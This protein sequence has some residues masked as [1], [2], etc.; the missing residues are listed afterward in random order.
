[1]L[2]PW[3]PF[4]TERIDGTERIITM[5]IFSLGFFG[6]AAVVGAAGI[7]AMTD[8]LDRGDRDEASRQGVLAGPVAVEQALANPVRTT[9]LAG[10]IAAPRVEARAE[11]LP[12][13]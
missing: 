3:P 4:S 7:G 5:S 9:Q 13:L 1:M 10:I 11:L 2:R 6:V 12:Y 8:A